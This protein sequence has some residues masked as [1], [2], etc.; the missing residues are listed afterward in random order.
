VLPSSADEPVFL[1]PGQGGD[2]RGALLEVCRASEAAAAE[3]E[4]VIE[5]IQQAAAAG[6]S[7]R[8]V[9]LAPPGS[10]PMEHGVPQLAGYAI[11]VILGRL[12][13]AITGPPAA[14]V[15]QSFGEIAALVCAGAFSVADGARAVDALNAAFRPVEGQGAM[16]LLPGTGE[17]D[18]L[19]LLAGSGI[20]DVVL[21]C[22]NSP[23]QTVVSGPSEAV[24]QFLALPGR[25]M[26]RL[27]VPYASHHPSLRP[28]RQRF[29]AGMRELRQRPLRLPVHSPVARRAY[30]DGD[31]LREALADC[32][33]EP[34]YLP[35][36]L[37]SLR[38]GQPGAGRPFI[39]LGTGDALSRCVQRTLPG[40]EVIAPLTGDPRWLCTAIQRKDDENA[41][42]LSR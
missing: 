19:A 41:S 7:I 30:T 27:P 24:E 5:E 23:D 38:T 15:G 2:P 35:E 40:A 34:V 26:I 14:I 13:A 1:V 8:A 22:V 39:E 32:V 6:S 21:A 25:K 3:A 28:V 16:V 4:A 9:L 10:V 29:L 36:T 12:L 42:A 17:A 18:C 33:V 37:L 11:S 20:S 31:D